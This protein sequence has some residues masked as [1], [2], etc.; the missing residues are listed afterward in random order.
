MGYGFM[1]NVTGAVK[2]SLSDYGQRVK[3][4]DAKVLM[5]T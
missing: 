5:P 3:Y 2:R 1:F 4:N